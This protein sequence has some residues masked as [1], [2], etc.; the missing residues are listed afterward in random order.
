[1]HAALDQAMLVM[2]ESGQ[3]QVPKKSKIGQASKGYGELGSRI[4]GCRVY[5]RWSGW[6]PSSWTGRGS[7]I[8]V[9]GDETCR[10]SLILAQHPWLSHLAWHEPGS[11]YLQAWDGSYG[12]A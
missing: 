9:D 3:S 8:S 12:A 2:Q 11:G 4:A 10:A 6:K 1:M 5:S 7:R